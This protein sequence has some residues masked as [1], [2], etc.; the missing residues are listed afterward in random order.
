M[1][2]R[3]RGLLQFLGSGAV[4]AALLFWLASQYTASPNYQLPGGLFSMLVMM[5]PGGFAIAGLIQ[6]ISGVPFSELSDKWDSLK[7][8]QRGVFGV[9]IFAFVAILLFGGIAVYLMMSAT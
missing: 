5:A 8:W 9:A 1:S 2:I 3:L 7:G 4:F 6:L